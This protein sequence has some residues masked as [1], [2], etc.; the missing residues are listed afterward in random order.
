MAEK[1]IKENNIND[2]NDIKNIC[3][4]DIC[5]LDE[6][7]DRMNTMDKSLIDVHEKISE[8]DKKASVSEQILLRLEIAFDKNNAINEKNIEVM[9]GIEKT[10]IGMQFEIKNNAENTT[11]IKK[12]IGEIKKKFEEIDNKGKIDLVKI[13]KDNIVWLFSGAAIVAIISILITIMINLDKI[14]AFFNPLAK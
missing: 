5:R 2:I 11:G 7:E 10:L 12:E 9:S 14:E 8:V 4:F 3:K 6:L 13:A 1:Y